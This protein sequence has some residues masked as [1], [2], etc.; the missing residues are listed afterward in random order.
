[1]PTLSADQQQHLAERIRSG[2]AD[3]ER[4]FV[5]LFATRIMAAVSQRIRDR[6]GAREVSQ[7]ILMA[8]I[9]ALRRDRL[10]NT[11]RLA[12]FVHGIARNLA[13]NYLRTQARSPRSVELEPGMLVVDPQIEVAALER[14]RL[15]V[16]ALQQ[17]EAAERQILHL[18][19]SEGLEPADIARTLG[20][21]S[22]V[23]RTRKSRALKRLVQGFQVMSRS[24]VAVPPLK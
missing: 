24:G 15:A 21:T 4:D 13:N 10:D 6:E 14:Q 8:A 1:M 17:L 3:A 20:L 16:R 22:D 5:A 9:V 12:A 11:E 19:L 7:D 18:T 2:D 23:V